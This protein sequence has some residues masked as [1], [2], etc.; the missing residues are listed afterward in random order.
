MGRHRTGDFPGIRADGDAGTSH[1]D[2]DPVTTASDFDTNTHSPHLDT[3][4]DGYAP[5]DIDYNV[6]TDE[7]ARSAGRYLGGECVGM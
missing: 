3:L 5:C 7:H 2:A 6:D 1:V 4:A